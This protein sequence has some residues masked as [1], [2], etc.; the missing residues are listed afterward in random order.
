MEMQV[1]LQ[2]PILHCKFFMNRFTDNINAIIHPQ[3]GNSV[4]QLVKVDR[5]KQLYYVNSYPSGRCGIGGSKTFNFDFAA[6][7]YVKSI[8]FIG[9][10]DDYGSV[11]LNG[12]TLINQPYRWGSS[13]WDEP[14][15]GMIPVSYLKKKQNSI[16]LSAYDGN[17]FG[18]DSSGGNG[19]AT[20]IT[21]YFNY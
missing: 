2:M 4:Y 19:T 13:Y 6:L 5:V 1:F 17:N 12:T 7:D 21:L 20:Y 3:I 15:S 10:S 18:C 16:T 8:S 11:V 14:V 9:T